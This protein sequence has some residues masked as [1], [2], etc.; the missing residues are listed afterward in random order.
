[1]SRAKSGLAGA[2]SGAAAGTAILPGIGTAIGAGL[3]GL[4]GLFSGSDDPNT[5]TPVTQEQ[6][7]TAN[8]QT[9][10]G[11][12]QQNAFVNALQAQNGIGNQSS[13]FNQLQGVANGTG[14]NPAQAALQQATG[15]NV[16]NQAALMA[17]QR[18]AGANTGLI[19]RQAAQQGANTQQQAIGQGATLQ[20]QQSLGALGQMGGIAGQQVGQQAGALQNL[21]QFG[22]ANQ[23]Q[24]LGATGTQTGNQN[25]ANQQNNNMIGGLLNGAGAAIG[26]LGGGKSPVDDGS[27]VGAI[28]HS[29][30]GSTTSSMPGDSGVALAAGGAVGPSSFVGRHLKM[31][32]GGKVPAMVSPQ[33]RYLSPAEV[34]KVASGKKSSI[35]AGEKIPGKPKVGGSVNDYSNDTVP[36][37]L[38]KGGIV[39][40]RS[41]T[42]GAD[43]HAAAAKFVAAILAKQGVS[44]KK[45]K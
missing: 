2:A 41:V 19:A 11:L 6:L 22:L 12:A 35:A 20:A 44:A 34:Q 5:V 21:N 39:I 27:P 16:A 10:S 8:A 23:G 1:M 13:T 3:G 26:A 9:Q 45:V 17:G 40:P 36:K 29:A 38:N 28:G 7:A 30:T 32:H 31:A 14:P 37:T 43:P 33:E 24:L 15:A 4:A 25:V 18:G 42:Q